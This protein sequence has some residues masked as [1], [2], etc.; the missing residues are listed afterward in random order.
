MQHDL[1]LAA[2]SSIS[3]NYSVFSFLRCVTMCIQV[4]IHWSLSSSQFS[5]CVTW[6][7]PV[8]RKQPA[9]PI[10]VNNGTEL[11]STSLPS[12]GRTGTQIPPSCS[13][14][15]LQLLR[16]VTQGPWKE[17][18][19]PPHVPP[20][21]VCEAVQWTGVGALSPW[22][23]ITLQCLASAWHPADQTPASS[24]HW[25]EPGR[26]GQ[27]DGRSPAALGMGAVQPGLKQ[28]LELGLWLWEQ[29]FFHPL[30]P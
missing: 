11:K 24:R 22:H 7:N 18:I 28:V 5:I 8:W 17:S 25:A 16:V 29:Y 4:S 6:S 1:F 27:G 26:K 21:R 23:R 12:S 13:F 19:G 3:S 2:R 10:H 14:T 20:P 30:A 15:W 9:T